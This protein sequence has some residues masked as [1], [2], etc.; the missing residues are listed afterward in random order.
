[1]DKYK[2]LIEGI[3][4]ELKFIKAWIEHIDED[5]P[6]L[7]YLEGRRDTLLEIKSKFN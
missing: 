1:M 5:D 4:K 2:I 3:E 6:M 7:P